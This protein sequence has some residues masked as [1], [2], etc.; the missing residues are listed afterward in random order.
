MRTSESLTASVLLLTSLANAQTLH[1]VGPGGF[2]QIRDAL[3]AAATGD[4]IH[5]HPGLYAQFSVTTSVTIRALT[6]GTVDVAFDP[7]VLPVGCMNSPSCAAQN[8][9]TS[10]DVPS[11]EAVHLDGVNFLASSVFAV[12]SIIQHHV[13][14]RSGTATLTECHLASDGP[15]ALHVSNATVHLMQCVVEGKNLLTSRGLTAVDANITAVDSQFFGTQLALSNAVPGE[16]VHTTRGTLHGSSLLLRG[17]STSLGLGGSNAITALGGSVWI[18]D[19]A[20]EGGPLSCPIHKTGTTPRLDRVTIIAQSF[21]CQSVPPTG[22]L[23]GISQLQPIQAGQQV[24]FN[25]RG[26][27]GALV[28]LFASHDLAAL[29]A[30]GI[31]QPIWIDPGSAVQVSAGTTSSSGFHVALIA[32]PNSPVLADIGIWIQ[33]ISTPSFPFQGDLQASP[34]V[35]GIVR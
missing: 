20:L 31:E 30:P 24:P 8:E 15:E 17:G 16:A 2:A 29:P 22:P 32:I 27:S 33:A 35:G 6:P 12:G 9:A 26:P 21:T 4:I 10:I 28:W 5:V 34:I 1:V 11:N 25:L 19:S 23:L 14:I 13:A 7:S 18:S 3:A